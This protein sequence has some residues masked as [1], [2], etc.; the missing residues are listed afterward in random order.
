[1]LKL[2]Y[3]YTLFQESLQ[4]NINQLQYC[5]SNFSTDWLLWKLDESGPVLVYRAVCPGLFLFFT[6]ADCFPGILDFC[7]TRFNFHKP[8]HGYFMLEPVKTPGT[9]KGFGKLYPS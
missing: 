3:G 4:N 6:P 5:H 1:M 7:E 2:I 9:Y 8:A